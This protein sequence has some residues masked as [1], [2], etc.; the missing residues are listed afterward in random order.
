MSLYIQQYRTKLWLP[1]KLKIHNTNNTKAYFRY[2]KANVF[3]CT[4]VK[5]FFTQQLRKHKIKIYPVPLPSAR[6]IWGSFWDWGILLS[7]ILTAA[8]CPKKYKNQQH[9]QEISHCDYTLPL[10]CMN[11]HKR[12]LEK[13]GDWGL[14]M[15]MLGFI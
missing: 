7:I 2:C 11:P 15:K 9:V 5:L 3:V 12:G 8:L 13:K 14:E 6:I 1:V 4:K 10:V